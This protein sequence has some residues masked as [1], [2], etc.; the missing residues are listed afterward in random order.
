MNYEKIYSDIC[1]RGKLRQ[2]TKCDGLEKH[3]IIP[4]FF[5]KDSK[6]KK[7]FRDGIYEGDGNDASN[8]TYL[9]AREHFLAHIILCKIWRHTRWYHRCMSSVML[10][11]NTID[12]RHTRNKTFNPSDSKKYEKYRTKAIDSISKMRKGTMPVKES[13]TGV[14][15]GSVP[16][17]HPKVLSGEWVHHSKG[18]KISANRVDKLRNTMKGLGNS[19]SKYSDE[20]LLHSFKKCCEDVGFVVGHHYWVTY[21]TSKG[22]PFVTTFKSF[23]FS[24]KGFDDMLN[25]VL[26]NTKLSLPSQSN[27]PFHSKEY[28]TFLK[29][30]AIWQSRSKR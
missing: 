20:E 21:A 22:L 6:R 13:E 25:Y 4:T 3:H 17:N 14:I 16:V 7:R 26:E 30:D 11:Y 18:K 19:N 9:T 23:R 28:K 24:G 1:A 8:I 29:G 2:K 5:F 12:S 10:F 15:V 27:K